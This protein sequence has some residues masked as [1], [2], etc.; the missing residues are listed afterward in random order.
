M[1]HFCT[2]LGGAIGAWGAGWLFDVSGS[3]A[4]ALATGAAMAVG[5]PALLW[6]VAPRRPNPPPP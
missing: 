5:A 4:V 2:S 3:Y 1:L 6:I